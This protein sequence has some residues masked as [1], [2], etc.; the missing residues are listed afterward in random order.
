MKIEG[1]VRG[2]EGKK[3][4]KEADFYLEN[5]VC[6]AWDAGMKHILVHAHL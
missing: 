4:R 6:E 1:G 3:I 2:R 5:Q